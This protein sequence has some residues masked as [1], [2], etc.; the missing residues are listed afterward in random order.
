MLLTSGATTKRHCPQRPV[1]LAYW[2]I[3][4]YSSMELNVSY[5]LNE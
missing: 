4:S 1:A 3:F 5:M 2:I